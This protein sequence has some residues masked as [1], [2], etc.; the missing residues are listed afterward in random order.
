MM[1]ALSYTDAVLYDVEPPLVIATDN[2]YP[3]VMLGCLAQID[4]VALDAS[5]SSGPAGA[6][7]QRL[8]TNRRQ[9]APGRLPLLLITAHNDAEH[10]MAKEAAQRLGPLVDSV[11][12]EMQQSRNETAI[13]ALN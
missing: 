1:H 3:S 6:R 2:V 10:Q 5:V 11:Q 12:I 13:K 8:L 4:V 9:V 7:A